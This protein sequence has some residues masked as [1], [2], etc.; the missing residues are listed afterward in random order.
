MT[1][2]Y[3]KE[4]L[5]GELTTTM[6]EL[7]AKRRPDTATLLAEI[8]NMDTPLV[9]IYQRS[10][11]SAGDGSLGACYEYRDIRTFKGWVVP[12]IMDW[13]LF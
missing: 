10:C 2:N 6:V 11:S 7:D 5:G 12:K 4:V 3:L 9:A 1:K 13:I 8:L